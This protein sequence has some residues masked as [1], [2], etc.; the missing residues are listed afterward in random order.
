MSLKTK[1]T[2]GEWQQEEGAQGS[3]AT[4]FR[5]RDVA[6]PL[7]RFLTVFTHSFF[8]VLR[9]R[10]LPCLGSKKGQHFGAR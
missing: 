3:G 6:L 5:P 4:D 9:S 10:Q 1:E 2:S 7:I 8:F